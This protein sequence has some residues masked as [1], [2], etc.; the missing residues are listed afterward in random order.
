MSEIL[1]NKSL[2]ESMTIS[3]K[4]KIAIAA[5][6]GFSAYPYNDQAKHCTVGT[7]ILLSLKPCT[8]KQLKTRYD[9]SGLN[10]TFNAR[11]YEAERY[12][13]NH[14]REAK[15]T[16]DQ[17]DCLVSFVFN[18]G[19]GHAQDALTFANSGLHE[20]IGKEMSSFIN[21]RVKD[22]KGKVHLQRSNG[23]VK[24]RE[25][26]SVPFLPKNKD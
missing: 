8:S 25:R 3:E 16:Q 20:E 24:R 23:L 10:K 4:G 22:K 5:D 6:E 17:Y 11:L 1:K 2:N 13:R 9:I 26:E 21:V 15:L 14:V 7:G 19:V 12:V 18:V